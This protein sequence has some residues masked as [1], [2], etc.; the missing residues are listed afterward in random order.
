MLKFTNTRKGISGTVY[1]PPEITRIGFST[2]PESQPI[3][4]NIVKNSKIFV[5][6]GRRD[7]RFYTDV[8]AL[9]RENNAFGEELD[10]LARLEFLRE[11]EARQ[12]LRL[13]IPQMETVIATRNLENEMEREDEENNSF[14]GVD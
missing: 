5:Y 1:I 2:Y 14:L 6:Q 9:M 13:A 11:R 10:F 12:Y 4:E 8:N 7:Y 3:F